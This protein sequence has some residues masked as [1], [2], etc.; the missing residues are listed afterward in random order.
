MA[1]V[2][3]LRTTENGR[4]LPSEQNSRRQEVH[5][6]CA[7]HEM[8]E[9]EQLSL[10]NVIGLLHGMKLF[11]YVPVDDVNVTGWEAQILNYLWW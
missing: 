6:P 11:L 8:T 7:L 10:R 2:L 3:Q 1:P 9:V 5:A 4:Q